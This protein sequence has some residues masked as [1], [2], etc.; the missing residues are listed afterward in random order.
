[1]RA[2]TQAGLRAKCAVFLFDIGMPRC[3]L[4][5]VPFQTFRENL[6]GGSPLTVDGRRTDALKL[7]GAFWRPFFPVVPMTHDS[8]Q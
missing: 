6:F 7:I 4:M 2:A 3:H 5:S 8:T 1:M